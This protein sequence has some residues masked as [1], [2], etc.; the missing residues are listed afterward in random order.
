MKLEFNKKYFIKI[1]FKTNENI[2]FHKFLD[3]NKLYETYNYKLAKFFYKNFKELHLFSSL[4]ERNTQTFLHFKVWSAREYITFCKN[5]FNIDTIYTNSVYLYKLIKEDTDLLL[6]KRNRFIF[7]FK[8]QWVKALFFLRNIK[9]LKNIIKD[10][11]ICYYF[12]TVSLNSLKG[13]TLVQ[14]WISHNSFENES[15]N[16]LYMKGITKELIQRRKKV[17]FL[18][19]ISSS[20]NLRKNLK[21]LNKKKIKFIFFEHFLNI[22]DLLIPIQKLCQLYKFYNSKEV[23]YFFG[24]NT[25]IFWYDEK[26]D[27]SML[28]EPVLKKIGIDLPQNIFVTNENH[29][30]QYLIQYFT[31]KFNLNTKIHG[32]FHTTFPNSHLSLKPL[33]YKNKNIT[34]LPDILLSNSKVYTNILKKYYKSRENIK[35]VLAYKQI[36]LKNVKK[37]SSEFD[38]LVIMPGNVDLIDQLIVMLNDLNK[39]Y[40]I[41]IRYH[42]MVLPKV[43]INNSLLNINVSDNSLKK[44]FSSTK[45]I[46]GTYSASLLEGYSYGLK[47]GLLQDVNDLNYNPFD[48]TKIRDYY[49]INHV[50]QLIEFL[51]DDHKIKKTKIREIFNLTENNF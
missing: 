35:N 18:F 7:F 15:F 5:N 42:P 14:T 31:K 1:K 9:I 43:K 20:L 44:D 45:N 40:K 10:Y 21:I 49:L 4:F 19:F 13:T 25:H 3:Q 17:S 36:Y 6:T 24:K 28:F 30:S 8:F 22:K 47:V 16:D 32:Y 11:F 34:P 23:E 2:N 50:K 33:I 29:K 12:S 41:L 51:K 46:I 38:L 26:I 27:R 37:N 39:Q 48:N